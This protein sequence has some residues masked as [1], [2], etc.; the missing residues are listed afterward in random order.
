MAGDLVTAGNIAKQ[1]GVSD[2]KV[3]KAIAA[4][5]LEPAAKKGACA[6][7]AATDIPKI[8]KALE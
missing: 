2:G 1:L 6:Y 5:N 7:Y 8:K 3:K 4:L